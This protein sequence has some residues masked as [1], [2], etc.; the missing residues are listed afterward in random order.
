MIIENMG[1]VELDLT[2]QLKTEGGLVFLIGF[3][4]GVALG[5]SGV[6]G[7]YH[8]AKYLEE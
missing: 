7:G 2:T 4:I 8:I 6:Y 3:V 1:V 5:A